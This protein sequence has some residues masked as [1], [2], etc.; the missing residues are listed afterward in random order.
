MEKKINSYAITGDS[1]RLQ[2]EGAQKDTN[3]E[4]CK[5]SLLNNS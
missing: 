2:N 3:I 4:S 1:P 5:S